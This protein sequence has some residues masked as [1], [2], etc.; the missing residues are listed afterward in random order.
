MMGAGALQRRYRDVVAYLQTRDP[1]LERYE[2]NRV[3]FTRKGR[4]QALYWGGVLLPAGVAACYLADAL[5]GTAYLNYIIG[6]PGRLAG[7]LGLAALINAAT[8]HFDND[9]DA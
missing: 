2:G 4:I 8:G 3:V 5:E 6:V 7:V 1:T 9:G